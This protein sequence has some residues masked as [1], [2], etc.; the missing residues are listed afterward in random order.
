MVDTPS[1]SGARTEA[2]PANQPQRRA[3]PAARSQLGRR[4]RDVVAPAA[5]LIGLFVL[6]E[7]LV[8]W[9]GIRSFILPRPSEILSTI[10]VDW[11]LFRGHLIFTLQNVLLGFALAFVVAMVLGFVV[12]HSTIMNRTIYPLLVASQTI[13]IIAIAP[14]FIIWFGYGILPKIITTALICFFPLTVNTVT[15]YL[16][17]DAD[18]RTLFRAYKASRWQTFR[19]LTFPSALPYIMSGIKISVTLSVIGGVIGEWIGSDQ[20]LG[21]MIIQSGAQIMTARVFASIALLSA[22]GVVLFLIA[23]VI[24]RRITPWR[25]T[26]GE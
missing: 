17:V 2:E 3:V 21:Y 25:H 24:D 1:T 18:M 12:A 8:V 15:G 4:I 16:S 22:M 11:S 7:L 20:G 9:L 5:L 13:P 14:V 26:M 6:W 19:K 23:S 10:W